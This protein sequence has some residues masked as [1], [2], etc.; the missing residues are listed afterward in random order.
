V[1]D[2]EIKEGMAARR[3]YRQWLD[4]NIVKLADLPPVTSLP[5]PFD[6][7]TLL[8]QQQAFG[9]SIEDLKMLMAPMAIN[10]QEA[11]GSMGTDTPPAVLSDRPQLL[12]AYFKQ[13][14]A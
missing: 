10:G 5:E 6:R 9:Y 8:E 11:V 1:G 14:F 2:D 13:L 12:F 7:T 3:P 4:E